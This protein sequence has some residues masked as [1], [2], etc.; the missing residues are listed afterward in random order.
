[1]RRREFIA[2]VAGV[3]AAWP[4][5]VRAQQRAPVVGFLNSGSPDEFSHLVAAFN[6][7]LNDAGFYDGQNVRIEYHWAEGRYQ[8]LPELAADL[9]R[10]QVAVI[11]ATGGTSSVAAAKAATQTIPIVFIGGGDPVTEGLVGSLNRPGANVT[12]ITV[13]S[14]DLGAKRLELLRELLP[15][16]KII[17]MLV[18][19]TGRNSEREMVQATAAKLGQRLRI[20][21]VSTDR[22]LDAAFATIAEERIEGLLVSGDALFNSRRDEIV[23]LATKYKTPTVFPW[24]EQVVAGGLLSYGTSLRDAYRQ[25]AGYVARILKG[26]KP[27]DLPA[28]R[29]SKFEVVLNLKTAKALGMKIP[30]LILLRADEV[31]E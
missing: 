10:R 11:A 3:A 16:A 7:G 12:G 15:T 25:A 21:E 23:R 30:P 5:T 28:Q 26:A 19:P 13:V 22:D 8:R 27:A 20:L 2:F 14:V 4:L 29:P 31:I 17:G 9:V 24:R 18:N 6:Q 1:M